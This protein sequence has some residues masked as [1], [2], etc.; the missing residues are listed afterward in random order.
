MTKNYKYKKIYIVYDNCN[1]INQGIDSTYTEL[2]VALRRLKYI[3]NNYLK[4][5]KKD[6]PNRYRSEED[7]FLWKIISSEL[8]LKKLEIIYSLVENIYKIDLKSMFY[9]EKQYVC[10]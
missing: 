5:W 8:S 4:E 2:K 6:E 1:L 3:I 9:I 10:N 7:K